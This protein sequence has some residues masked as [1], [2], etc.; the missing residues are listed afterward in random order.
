MSTG[1]WV[2]ACGLAGLLVL[3]ACS[4]G[5]NSSASSSSST[6]QA[7]TLGADPGT[8]SAGDPKTGAY[9]PTGALIA[10]SGFRPEVNGFKFENYGGAPAGS[11]P[12]SNLVADDVRKLFGDAV[13]AD[14]ASG[15]CD[16]IPE[17]QAWMESINN[18]MGGGHCYGFSVA[19]ELIWR[20]QTPPATFGADATPALPI[21]G[22][23][24]LQRE[25]AYDWA[26][27]TLGAVRA[28]QIT[29][30]P[31]DILSKLKEVLVPNPSETYTVA[32]F[33]RDGQGGHAV[34]P[35]AIED[36]GNGVQNLLIYDNNW[37][38]VTREITFDTTKNT[39]NYVAA[40]NPNEPSEVYEGDASTQ[41][42]SL[43]PTSPGVGTQPCPFC[44]KVPAPAGGGSAIG[45]RG[46]QKGARLVSARS[47]VPNPD[48][49][50]EIYLEGSDT[51]HG[52]LLITDAAGHRLGIVD[53]K[54]VNEIPGAQAVRPLS[55]QNWL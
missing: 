48:T 46:T 15:K 21:D 28:A 39:W 13:C 50:V 55:S 29:G 20:R 11:P 31:N 27:Q 14:A 23:A 47:A 41:S 24:A 8:A 52:H 40:T 12:R 43:F 34:T 36:K 7:K 22:N 33:R 19:A 42:I 45:A 18:A 53:G 1:R 35:Y 54:I 26:F 37:P 4:S 2:V 10:D 49:T 6:P 9:T 16:L 17:G 32:I 25:L 5:S 3:G 51:N 44:Q 30:T 38:G